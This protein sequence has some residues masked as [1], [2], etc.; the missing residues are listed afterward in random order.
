MPDAWKPPSTAKVTRAS[1][2]ARTPTG[3]RTSR[4]AARRI[5]TSPTRCGYDRTVR[6]VDPEVGRVARH[7]ES[8]RVLI[9]LNRTVIHRA[10]VAPVQPDLDRSSHRGAQSGAVPLRRVPVQ[11]LIVV[12]PVVQLASGDVVDHNGRAPDARRG[13]D[14]DVLG[15]HARGT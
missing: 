2:P 10:A 9:R 7:L 15:V 11:G 13:L 6:V 1:A 4:S 14:H 8:R 5:V 3:T 12:G